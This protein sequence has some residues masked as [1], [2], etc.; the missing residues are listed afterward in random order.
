MKLFHAIKP[1]IV[2]AL[3][4]AA[5][6]AAC[7]APSHLKQVTELSDG[8]GKVKSSFDALVEDERKAFIDAQTAVALNRGVTI[9]LAPRCTAGTKRKLSPSDCALLIEK[10]GATPKKATFEPAVRNGSALA[11]QLAAYGNGLVTL[12]TAKDL[13]ELNDATGKASSAILKLAIEAGGA[14]PE[15]LTSI[16]TFAVWAT[17]QYLQRRRFEKLRETVRSADPVVAKTAIVLSAQADKLQ[18]N[19]IDVR[20]NAISDSTNEFN[21]LKANKPDDFAAQQKLANEIVVM[22]VSLQSL[23]KADVV[24]PFQ[25]MRQAH[26]ELLSSLENPKIA[27]EE[28]FS[29]ISDF[30]DQIEK[31]KS[32]IEK[33]RQ[34][35]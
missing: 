5:M 14:P 29:K 22:T 30:V 34:G 28:V 12:T 25:K 33:G 21:K 4:A 20:A 6:L 18:R 13:P 19:I 3:A 2:I 8:F 10:P 24:K 35:A 17:N 7:S 27:P 11:A 31:L 23:V 9:E 1:N 15:P 26:S 32:G 16:S